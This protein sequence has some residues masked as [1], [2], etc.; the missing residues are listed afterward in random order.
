[1]YFIWMLTIRHTLLYTTLNPQPNVNSREAQLSFYYYSKNVL[2]WLVPQGPLFWIAFMWFICKIRYNQ[3]IC[4]ALWHFMHYHISI[5]FK[6]NYTF[7]HHLDL[8]CNIWII[9]M[10][11]KRFVIIIIWSTTEI[12]SVSIFY[13]L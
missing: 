12:K 9:T 5:R 13:Q 1:M 3:L 4:N 8:C 11:N 2:G 6:I 7:R 10:N